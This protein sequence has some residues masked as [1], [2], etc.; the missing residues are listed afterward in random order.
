[1]VRWLK[2]KK[3]KL[4]RMKCMN[5]MQM[6]TIKKKSFGYKRLKELTQGPCQPDSLRLSLLHPD[7]FRCKF[8]VGISI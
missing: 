1:M 7:S 5:L 4:P 2:K 8:G 3:K 6:Q